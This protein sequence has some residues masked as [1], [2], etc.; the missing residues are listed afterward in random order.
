[1]IR[2]RE[3]RPARG[4]TLCLLVYICFTGIDSSAK[5][6]IEAGLPVFQIVFVRYLGHLLIVIGTSGPSQGRALLRMQSPKL[7]LLRGAML[8]TATCAN[9]IALQFLPLTITTS[10]VFSAPLIVTALAALFLGEKVGPRRWVA[11]GVGFLGVLIITQPFGAGFQWAMLISCIPP[12]AASVYALITR[13]LAGIEAP[14]TMQF[15]AAFL[16]V[17]ALAP[18]A[19]LDWRWPSAPVDWAVFI[20]IGGFGW[21]GHQLYTVAH[22]F[23]EASL[24]APLNYVQIIYVTAAS[25]LIFHHPPEFWT[26]IGVGVIIASGLYVW[27][28]E[29][30]VGLESPAGSATPPRS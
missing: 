2:A 27:L 22:R 6:L 4:V 28:R 21:L 19:F 10:I 11:I 9:F 25:W 18:I 12:F 3:D 23:A 30:Q 15:W 5:W 8:V 17:C 13:R 1:M 26:L 20:C 16:P 29:R 14:E 7:T 24:L